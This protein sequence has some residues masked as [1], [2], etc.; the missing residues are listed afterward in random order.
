MR[1]F[2]FS[3]GSWSLLCFAGCLSIC[4]LGS[5]WGKY[6]HITVFVVQV[7]IAAGNT[8]KQPPWEAISR[9]VIEKI[10]TTLW[11]ALKVWWKVDWGHWC[12]I[13]E[14]MWIVRLWW[15]CCSE[16]NGALVFFLKTINPETKKMSGYEYQIRVESCH[17]KQSGVMSELDTHHRSYSV[18]R[19][20]TLSNIHARNVFAKK[21]L[22]VAS[23]T[24]HRPRFRSLHW[25]NGNNSLY[26]WFRQ[27]IGEYFHR[28]SSSP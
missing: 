26:Q 9:R 8:T 13:F 14:M 15:M 3:I 2:S 20:N 1:L 23:F 11:N 10:K 19:H 16:E 7:R 4:L 22:V 12:L 25:G 28:S 6:L 21:Y 5:R 24:E 17:C 18:T 27:S